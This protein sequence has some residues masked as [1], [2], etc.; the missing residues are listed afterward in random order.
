MDEA[1]DEYVD[2]GKADS[3]IAAAVAK[4]YP[5]V[6]AISFAGMHY[7]KDIAFRALNSFK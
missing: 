3:D 6:A 2:D 7:R 4:V 1:R 5:A